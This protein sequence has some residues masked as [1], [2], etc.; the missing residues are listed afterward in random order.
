VNYS[1][2]HWNYALSWV[3]NGYLQHFFL[4]KCKLGYPYDKKGLQDWNDLGH[5][6]TYIST[7][8]FSIRWSMTNDKYFFLFIQ[9]LS[10]ICS[11]LRKFSTNLVKFWSSNNLLSVH[12]QSTRPFFEFLLL[13]NFKKNVYILCEQEKFGQVDWFKETVTQDFRSSI[14][15]NTRRSIL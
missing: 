15:F 10:M 7:Q 14:I 11:L 4:L 12:C 2:P 8:N 3:R 13:M 5:K 9:R 1:A 6:S